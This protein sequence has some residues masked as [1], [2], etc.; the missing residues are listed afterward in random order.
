MCKDQSS[1]KSEQNIAA[2]DSKAESKAK[3]IKAVPTL[4][5]G[6]VI[7]SH[8]HV[9]REFFAEERDLVL[10]RAKGGGVG[11]MVNPAVTLERAALDELAEL[12]ARNDWIFAACGLHPHE[13][14]DWQDE[15][16][17]LVEEYLA[18]PGFVA[19]GECGLDFFYDNS[20]REIQMQ[21]LARQVELAVKHNLPIIIHCRDAWSE[22]FSILKEYGK[23]KLR[24]V[25]HCFTGGPEHLDQINGLDFY[26]SFSGILTY[27]KSVAIQE[28]AA[29]VRKDRMLVETDCPF[30]APQSVRGERNEPLFV[31]WTAEKLAQLRNISLDEVVAQTT[32]NA[33]QL[34][35]I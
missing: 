7:D 25:F 15:S 2:V 11:K 26:V 8:A 21:V 14:K 1:A 18:K 3:K 22:T 35:A 20:P 30:L 34:F 32:A 4:T 6:Y 33:E 5:Q 17:A 24:G 29:L 9:T 16:A 28:A 31:L 13:A 27:K 10:A 12:T 23:G 19:V